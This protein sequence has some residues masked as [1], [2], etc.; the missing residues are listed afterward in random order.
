MKEIR[1]KKTA[2][3]KGSRTKKTVKEKG[4]ESDSQEGEGERE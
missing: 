4:K 2:K 3:E 1:G